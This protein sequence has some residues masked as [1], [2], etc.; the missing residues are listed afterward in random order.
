MSFYENAYDVGKILQTDFP[1]VQYA[2]EP[3]IPE[4]L[5]VIA[6]RPKA[7]KSWTMLKLAYAVQNGSEF[8]NNE[9]RQGDVLYLALEDNKRR[10]KDRIVKL[11]LDKSLQH[12]TIVDEAPYLNYGLEESIE[13]WTKEVLNPRLVVIDTLAKVNKQFDKTKANI[14]SGERICVR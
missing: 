1:P 4:G 5:G 3:I 11:G 2:V 8:L 12:P 14:T 10:M 9:S 6:G 13:E 7:M